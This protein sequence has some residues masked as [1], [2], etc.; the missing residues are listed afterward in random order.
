[1]P[2]SAENFLE[3]VHI[4]NM[5]HFF[6]AKP[7][8]LQL[9]KHK[10]SAAIKAMEQILQG[11]KAF[12]DCFEPELKVNAIGTV[13]GNSFGEGQTFGSETEA[14]SQQPCDTLKAGDEDEGAVARKHHMMLEGIDPVT[15]ARSLPISHYCRLK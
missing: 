3:M 10:K 14:S 1:M 4:T 5:C 9:S 7:F 12:L 2:L 6:I 13:T 11:C 15:G 8:I